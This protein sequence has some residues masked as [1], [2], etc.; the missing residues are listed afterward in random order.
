MTSRSVARV[1][2][3]PAKYG[4]AGPLR[5][6]KKSR[7]RLC[8]SSTVQHTGTPGQNRFSAMVLVTVIWSSTAFSGVVKRQKTNIRDA[9]SAC[10]RSRSLSTSTLPSMAV[11]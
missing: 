9:F 11:T 7:F 4:G 1:G 5:A 10:T 8:G 3:W 2:A 6:I